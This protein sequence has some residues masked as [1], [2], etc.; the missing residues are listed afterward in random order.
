MIN[1]LPPVEK[2]ELL[3]EKKKRITIILWLL[4]LFFLLCLILILFSVKIY[5]QIQA[6]SQ[7]TLLDEAREEFGQSEIQDFREEINSV[8]LTLTKLN[9]FYQQKT[10]FSKIL[11]R[12]SGILPQGI[13]LTNFSAVFGAEKGEYIEV[14]LSGLSP[15]AD[16]LFEFKGNLEKESDFEDI[17]F[18]PS[19]WVKL[20]DINFLA[21]FKIK[22]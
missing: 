2:E 8:N 22:Q 12:I 20:I 5:L 18:P 6:E 13:Y 19:N 21:T 7:K 1:L 9:S 4:V 3:L 16:S 17:Y 15:T 11:E 14:S 10:Y